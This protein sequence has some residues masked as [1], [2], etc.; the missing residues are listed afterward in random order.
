MLTYKAQYS[1]SKAYIGL[2]IILLSLLQTSLL[3]DS[4]IGQLAMKGRLIDDSFI[5]MRIAQNI[6]DGRGET[7]DGV[8]KTNGYQ[9]LWVWSMV[10][11]FAAIHDPSS[12]ALV[13][14][15]L[16]ELLFHAALILLLV[17]IGKRIDDLLTFS[18]VG[19]F[20][21]L[22]PGIK[23][24]MINGLEIPLFLFVF[25]AT[26]IFAGK[27]LDR[28]ETELK[29][30]NGIILGLLL[31]LTFYARLDSFILSFVIGGIILFMRGVS[32]RIKAK[33]LSAAALTELICVVP[34]LIR[35][36]LVYGHI[37][38]L[39][40]AVKQWYLSQFGGNLSSYFSSMEWAG[41]VSLL[42]KV[43]TSGEPLDGR[44]IQFA[45]LLFFC[46][47]AIAVAYF[48]SKKGS[49]ALAI[50]A[51]YGATHLLFFV[52]IYRE[53]RAYTRYYFI[54]EVLA[55]SVASVLLLMWLFQRLFRKN[56]GGLVFLLLIATAAS[57]QTSR[58]DIHSPRRLSPNIARCY[59]A[60][61]AEENLPKDELF[62][63]FWPGTFSFMSQRKV[64][65]LDG[66]CNDGEFFDEYLKKG[67][68]AEYIL[69]ENIRFIADR[70]DRISIDDRDGKLIFKG[71]PSANWTGY[72]K[73]I[74]IEE[75]APHLRVVR[76]FSGNFYIFEVVNK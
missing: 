33:F 59:A 73:D 74:T 42:Q 63:A 56:V 26:A 62:G 69:E 18:A 16:G 24:G 9:P 17:F 6:A 41:P 7:F 38:P 47:S 22:F 14:W 44:A 1:N 76:K 31:S 11:I 66:I 60:I 55:L 45:M 2:L 68:V 34:Y 39:S 58:K 27:L 40:G 61:W 71:V 30:G 57:L 29:T 10:P 12:A 8:H 64:V 48:A 67:K 54:V 3:F 49:G 15:M 25:A 23:I 20:L 53:N 21:G 5:S 28:R 52:S 13:C 4:D 19:F 35:N 70:F 75:L 72:V 43:I 32:A 36:R 37:M 65:D 46:L 51:I 50:F